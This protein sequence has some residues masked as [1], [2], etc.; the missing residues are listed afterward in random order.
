MGWFFH[1][2]VYGVLRLQKMWLSLCELQHEEKFLHYNSFK[3]RNN[4]GLSGTT[5]TNAVVK[6][7]TPLCYWPSIFDVWGTLGDLRR[8]HGCSFWVEELVWKTWRPLCL[9]YSSSMFYVGNVENERSN[10]ALNGAGNLIIEK[11]SSFLSLDV[12]V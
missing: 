4:T 1:G 9:E 10:H 11:K 3:E 2:K 7:W 6:Q 12:F 8:S 5:S